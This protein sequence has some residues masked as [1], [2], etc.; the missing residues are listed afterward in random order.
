ML[1]NATV[2]MR[3]GNTTTVECDVLDKYTENEVTLAN[4]IG[5]KIGSAVGVFDWEGATYTHNGQ[6]QKIMNGAVRP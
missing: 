3:D 4:R 2:T 1:Y 6:E 5:N